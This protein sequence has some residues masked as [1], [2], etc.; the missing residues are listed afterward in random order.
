MLMKA[1]NFTEIL[2]GLLHRKKRQKGE[3][4]IVWV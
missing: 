2:K 3:L 4:L 1:D